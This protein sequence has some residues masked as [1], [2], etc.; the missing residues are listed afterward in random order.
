[1][2]RP[3]RGRESRAD[4][5]AREVELVIAAQGGSKDAFEQL[6]TLYRFRLYKIIFSITRNREDAEDALQETFL[7]AFLALGKFEGRSKFGSWLTRI[8]LNSALMRI[9]E[10]RARPEVLIGQSPETDDA[11]TAFDIRDSGSDPEQIYDQ[12]QRCLVMFRAI[13]KLGPKLQA[14]MRIR[15]LQEWSVKEIAEILGISESAAKSRLLRARRRLRSSLDFPAGRGRPPL[16]YE[17]ASRTV[18]P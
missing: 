16:N 2:S 18:A 7:S 15:T 14:V 12:H 1:M 13:Q 9:R 8:A 11:V 4:G 6:Q 3:A 17:N 5:E 10:R